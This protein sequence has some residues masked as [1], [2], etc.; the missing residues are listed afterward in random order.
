VTD[1]Q[2]VERVMRQHVIQWNKQQFYRAVNQ[3]RYDDAK[4]HK[5]N[6]EALE[7]QSP[8]A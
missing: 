1:E 8:G 5:E 3:E 4:R 6:I 2:T 7:S